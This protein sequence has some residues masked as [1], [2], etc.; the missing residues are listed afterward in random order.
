MVSLEQQDAEHRAGL[1]QLEAQ[2]INAACDDPGPTVASKLL[3]PIIRERLL[4]TP[5]DQLQ[6]SSPLAAHAADLVITPKVNA[7]KSSHDGNTHALPECQGDTSAPMVFWQSTSHA[8]TVDP[9]HLVPS[10]VVFL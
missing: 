4:G 3:L 8:T 6:Q 9:R 5:Q 10:Y 7:T 1:I 2:V